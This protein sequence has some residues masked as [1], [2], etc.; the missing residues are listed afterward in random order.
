MI[1]LKRIKYLGLKIPNFVIQRNAVEDFYKTFLEYF[2]GLELCVIDFE[3]VC[4]MT[5]KEMKLIMEQIAM[6]IR[7]SLSKNRNSKEDVKKF[8]GAILNSL[9]L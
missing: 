8:Y 7:N 5:D 2:P 1:D 4:T 9:L 3:F 6:N